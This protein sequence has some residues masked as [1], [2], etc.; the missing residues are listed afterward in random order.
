MKN[1]LKSSASKE[2]KELKPKTPALIPKQVNFNEKMNI[3]REFGN[4]FSRPMTTMTASTNFHN[5]RP[6]TSQSN[7]FFGNNSTL[8]QNKTENVSKKKEVHPKIA[9]EA[10][11]Q[12]DEKAEFEEDQQ[13]LEQRKPILKKEGTFPKSEKEIEMEKRF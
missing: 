1:T 9:S 8:L 12:E 7:G 2:F 13:K 6:G 5:T 3:E 10:L 11:W 4:E